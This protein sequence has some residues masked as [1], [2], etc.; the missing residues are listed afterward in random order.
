MMTDDNL[1]HVYWIGGSSCA[2]KSTVTRQLADRFGMHLYDCDAAFEVHEKIVSPEQFPTLHRLSRLLWNDLWMRPVDQQVSEELALYVEEWPL[3]LD[4]LRRLPADRPVIAEG[5]ALLPEL[6]DGTGIPASR[7]I[8]IVSAP[9]FQ[10]E[11]YARR[12]WVPDILATCD[13]PEQAWHNWMDRDAG[14]AAHVAA[15]ARSRGR[16]VITVDGSEP[17]SQVLERV[18]AHF[19]LRPGCSGVHVG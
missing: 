11:N 12:E 17:V 7:T 5:N 16:T 4:D 1:S 15:Q 3:I 18:I 9:E 6:F 8:W 19:G 13:D 14:F 10:R 2:G